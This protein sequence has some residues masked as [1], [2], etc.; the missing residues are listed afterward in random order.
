MDTVTIIVIEYIPK[1]AQEK[2]QYGTI[3]YLEHN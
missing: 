3:W 1:K 2:V